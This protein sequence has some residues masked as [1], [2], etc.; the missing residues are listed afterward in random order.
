[1]RKKGRSFLVL[2]IKDGYGRWT[3]PKG[4]IDKGES[5]RE[6]AVREIAEETGIKKLVVLGKAG[7]SK[8]FF[9][10]KGRVVFKRVFLYLC[11]TCQARFK[12]Q[13]SEIE[14]AGWFGPEEALCKIEYRGSR[15]LLKKAITKFASA[16]K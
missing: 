10:R 5:S 3:W 15:E 14:D 1:M 12:I 2:L 7:E 13:K 11:E 9:R 8:Y 16:M 4:H 6:A